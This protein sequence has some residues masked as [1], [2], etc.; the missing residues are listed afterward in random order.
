MCDIHLCAP[1]SHSSSMI[2]AVYYSIRGRQRCV[3]TVHPAV[4]VFEDI[5]MHVEHYFSH[6][7][8]D[9]R[10]TAW[11]RVYFALQVRGMLTILVGKASGKSRSRSHR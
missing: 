7:C 8:L 11:G 4:F 10:D 3:A 2:T 5:T 6:R 9:T 1:D